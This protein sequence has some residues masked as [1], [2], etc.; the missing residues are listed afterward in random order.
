ML[1]LRRENNNKKK[2]TRANTDLI[3]V[4]DKKKMYKLVIISYIEISNELKYVQKTWL[5]T[6]VRTR[7]N[8]QNRVIL[9]LRFKFSIKKFKKNI[10]FIILML[11]YYHF[12]DYFRAHELEE[13][14][15]S[16]NLTSQFLF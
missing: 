15:L 1:N 11:L 7:N 2:M 3:L 9:T 5:D 13:H 10:Y 8:R 6:T 12:N 16:M 14:G 4:L